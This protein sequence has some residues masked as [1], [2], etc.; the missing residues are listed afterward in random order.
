METDDI[1]ARISQKLKAQGIEPRPES[2]ASKINRLVTEFGVPPFEAE[3]T[4][5][6]DILKE[7]GVSQPKPAQSSSSD[8]VGIGTIAPGEW[9]TVEG[10]VISVTDPPSPAVAQTGVIADDTGAVRFVIFAK[11]APALL[12]VGE[13]FRLESAVVDEFRGLANL[14]IHGGTTVTPINEDRPLTPEI[15]RIADLR[16]G[17]ASVTAKVVQDW[18][19]RHDR[20]LQTGLLGD[21][22]GTVKFI[23]WKGGSDRKLEPDTVY[24]F[25]FVPVEEY[26]GRLSL[27]IDPAA[28]IPSDSVIAVP[29]GPAGSEEPMPRFEGKII[30]VRTVGSDTIRES[31]IIATEDGAYAFTIWADA[32]I[33]ALE[34]GS[35]YAIEGATKGMFR[36]APRISINQDAVVSP[37]EDRFLP[38]PPATPVADLTPGIATVRVKRVQEWENRSDRM[39][40]NGLV[41]DETGVIK[42]VIWGGENSEKIQENIVYTLFYASVEEYNGRLSLDLTHATPLPDEDADIEVS[43]GGTSISGALVHVASGSGIVKRCPVDGCSRVLSRQNFCPVHEFQPGFRYDLRIRGVLDD[44]HTAHNLLIQREAVEKLFSMTLAEAQDIAENQPLG[45]DEV[46]RQLADRALGRYFKVTGREFEGIFIAFDAQWL[47]FDPGRH[48]ALI[49]RAGGDLA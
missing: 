49:N 22:S 35:W 19:V 30:S 18:D 25:T 10:K 7:H 21:E 33:P 6:Q 39:L 3:R 9:V 37:V 43:R 16:P 41:G 12:K 11:N 48:T 32:Q 20:M 5:L 44:G 46:A 27:T 2:I 23:I 45:A 15:T 24:T 13:W 28:C 31:G 4:I 8:T 47:S 26:N 36:G 14:K 1:I 34:Q 17:I 29:A 40:Q 38:L 42:F